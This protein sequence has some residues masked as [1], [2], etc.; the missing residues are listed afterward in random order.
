[1]KLLSRLIVGVSAVILVSK[2]EF[3][4]GACMLIAYHVC[5]IADILEDREGL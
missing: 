4:A 5:R 1:M 3:M 2:Y